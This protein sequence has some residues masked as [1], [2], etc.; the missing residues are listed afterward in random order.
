VSDPPESPANITGKTGSKSGARL[1]PSARRIA[2][3]V[4]CRVVKDA[5]FASAALDSELSRVALQD[6]RERGLATE[7]VYGTLRMRLGLLMLLE[8]M[9]P[10]GLKGVDELAMA[11]LLVGAYQIVFLT[12]VPAF[13]AVDEA[14]R[15]IRALRGAKL[16]GFLNALLRRLV[17]EFKPG[18]T[19]QRVRANAL[20]KWLKKGLDAS[21]APSEVDALLGS[22][23]PAQSLCVVDAGQRNAIIDAMLKL[24][25]EAQL[26]CGTL[27]PY[28]I[29]VV[30]AGPL[31]ALPGCGTTWNVQEEGSQVIA[32]ALG[33]KAGERVLDAC[34]GRGNKTALLASI[35]GGTGVLHASDVHPSKLEVVTARGLKIDATF[36]VDLTRGS[37]ALEGLY[38]AI[39]VDAPCSGTGTL[40]RRPDILFHRKPEHV[41]ELQAIQIAIL[42][43]A[44]RLLAPGGR[45]VYAVCSLLRSEAEQVLEALQDVLKPRPFAGPIPIAVAAELATSF[46]LLPASHGTDG[47]FVASLEQNPAR[48]TPANP[49]STTA[50]GAEP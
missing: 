6:R 34:A 48:L 20:P 33:A 50:E 44:S 26:T 31:D 11:H 4:L 23:V 29:R 5:A 25:P 27:S 7:L 21:L 10:R 41:A 13:A 24:H 16:A 9:A 39:L 1:A 38:D 43:T 17:R 28:A 47:Y 15:E 18:E 8:N 35:L 46:R 30:M 12:R 22:E 2:A 32:V 19:P 40:A 45:I 36:A 37:G 14:V 3:N 49:G 42:R